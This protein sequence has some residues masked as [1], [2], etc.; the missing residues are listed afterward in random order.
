MTGRASDHEAREDGRERDEHLVKLTADGDRD[1]FAELMRRHEDL[2]FGT[3]LRLVRDRE[4]ALDTTQEVF[5]TVFRKASRFRGESAFTTWLYRIAVNASYDQLRKTSR[6]RTVPLPEQHD[7]ADDSASA[8][9]ESVELRPSVLD[10]LSRIPEEFRAA[11]VLMDAQGLSVAE[12][13]GILDVPPGTVKSRVFRARRLLAKELG[14]LM[15]DSEHHTDEH[16][17]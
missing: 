16:H 5:I 14:N 15:D 7:P 17:A 3:C 13:A 12:T 4:L 10:A 8:P 6:R 1:A 9:F 11:I 2:V